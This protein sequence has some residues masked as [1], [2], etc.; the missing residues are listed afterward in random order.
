MVYYCYKVTNIGDETLTTHAL[1]DNVLGTVFSGLSYSLAPGASVDTVTLGLNLPMV[2]NATITNT[3]TWTATNTTSSVQAT[4]TATVTAVPPR[5]PGGGQVV[6]LLTA[7]FSTFP[8]AGWTLSNTGTTC[9]AGA[10]NWNNTDAGGR[11]NLTGGTGAFAIAD[12]DDCGSGAVVDMRM[13][14]PL[15][16][17][18]GLSDP[19]VEFKYDY[20][21]LGSADSGA[22]DVSVD[23][24]ATWANE[25]IFT[26]DDR[27]PKTYVSPIAG[28]GDNDVAL[29]WRYVAAWDWWWEVDDVTVTA[30]QAVACTLTPPAN[31]SVTAPSGTT[32]APVS[33]TVAASAGCGTVTCVPASGSLFP[34]GTTTV[35]CTSQFGGGT[36]AFTVTVLAQQSVLEIP[37]LAPAGLGGLALLLAGGAIAMLRRRRTR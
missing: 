29:R 19:Q 13:Q 4:D 7:D 24:G 35:N 21:D 8:P 25:V 15:L 32:T 33:F 1:A 22:V 26:T 5:C 17:M 9:S 36:T 10:P 16:D 6:T 18:T 30:C 3:A 12:S 20:N 31:I 2:A 11:G 37:T 28:A 27:G 34:L 23:A 14:T